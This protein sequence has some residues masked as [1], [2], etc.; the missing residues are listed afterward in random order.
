MDFNIWLYSILGVLVVS[1][2]S[3]MGVFTLSLG[4]IKL[5]KI[6]LYLVSFAVGALFGDAL[7]HLIPESFE[8]IQSSLN[9]SLLI[10]GGIIVFFVLEKFI[11]WRHCHV[12]DCENHWH[13]IASMNII[14]NVLHNLIDGMLI[15]ASFSE[16]IALGITTTIAI[17]LHEIPQEIGNFSILIH[18]GFSVKKAI[19]VNF[20]T[21]LASLGGAVIALIIGGY[22]SNFA[23]VLL[24]ITAGGFLY[25][26]GSD[27]I[28]ELKHESKL[29]ASLGQLIMICVGIFLMASLVFLAR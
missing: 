14:G 1:F 17:L 2:A 9:V 6:I 23:L 28:P 8:K 22:I 21:A 10:L 16:S 3:L 5:K 19:L 24:P 29:A 12:V 20:S 7:I 25:I 11:H 27:L 15:G 18:A 4:H 26:A 13:P